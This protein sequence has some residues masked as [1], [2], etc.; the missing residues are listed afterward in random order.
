MSN[1]KQTK[2]VPV[3]EIVKLGTVSVDVG[4]II[5]ADPCR[6]NC[7]AATQN[8]DDVFG[9]VDSPLMPRGTRINTETGEGTVDELARE[10]ID[11]E[12]PSTVPNPTRLEEMGH[13]AGKFVTLNTGFGDGHYDVLAEVINYG[14][15]IGRRI[16]AIH[17]QF[18]ADED[19]HP[20]RG[21]KKFFE[22]E[23][24]PIEQWLDY[25]IKNKGKGKIKVPVLSVAAADK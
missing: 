4:T 12:I 19:L 14:G 10:L 17:M 1:K 13:S 23:M 16:A 15:I 20:Y 3:Y 2:K 9:M 22:V 18:V 5:I 25:N 7:I 24:N 21:S 8:P 6:I 11:P